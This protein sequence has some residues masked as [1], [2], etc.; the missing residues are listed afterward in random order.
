MQILTQPKESEFKELVS[1]MDY[2]KSYH[3]IDFLSHTTA[4]YNCLSPSQQF[5]KSS[6]EKCLLSVV[7]EK[8]SS[9]L[10]LVYAS[11]P[12]HIFKQNV[13]E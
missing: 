11:P 13:P 12:R 7:M 6:R 4:T 1:P 10:H 2:F 5:L 3:N 8:F 9:M